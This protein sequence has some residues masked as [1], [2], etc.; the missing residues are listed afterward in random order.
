MNIEQLRDYC[1]TKKGVT[2]SFPFD[3][4]TLVFKVM[5]KMFLLTDLNGWEKG[6]GG[7]NVK[8]NPDWAIELREQYKSI[9]PAFHMNKKHWN[10]VKLTSREISDTFGKEFIDHSYNLVVKGFTKK[11][12]KAL[13][14]L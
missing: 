14:N 9:Q 3:K 1:I 12:K 4:T 5:N 13:Q 6:D 10:T 8:C 7:I 11:Q 2:E